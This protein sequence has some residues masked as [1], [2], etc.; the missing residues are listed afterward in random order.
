MGD[1]DPR[2]PQPPEDESVPPYYAGPPATR[3]PDPAFAQPVAPPA[4][5]APYPTYAPYPS[6]PPY[7]APVRPTLSPGRL[8]AHRV[9]AALAQLLIFA[10]VIQH[11]VAW[12]AISHQHALLRQ[13]LA[14]PFS[15]SVDDANAADHAVSTAGTVLIVLMV[16]AGIA[17]IVWLFRLRTDL[18]VLAPDE[19][20]FAKGMAIGGWFIPIANLVLPFA[21]VRDV[22]RSTRPERD[23]GTDAGSG[24]M[25]LVGAWWALW[26]IGAV[27]SRFV[28]LSGADSVSGVDTA[29]R[30][31][32]ALLAVEAVAGLLAIAVI[33]ALTRANRSC[34]ATASAG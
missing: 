31:L 20:H 28:H 12:R 33:E 25:W 7:P 13:A 2:V 34:W 10:D 18:D 14:D 29:Y 5:S 4:G 23:W 30:E 15:V 6:Y 26:V 27:G 32:I 17:L 16:A 22:A 1:Y 21:V 8:R 11:V 19:R 24:V 3:P 9:W